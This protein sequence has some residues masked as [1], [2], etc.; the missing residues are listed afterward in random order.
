MMHDAGSAL[1]SALSLAF[2]F[3]IFARLLALSKYHCLGSKPGSPIMTND[4]TDLCAAC[5]Y[6]NSD[7]QLLPIELRA[8]I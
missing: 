2:I 6:P 1:I 8:G 3:F 5:T 4:D 7:I